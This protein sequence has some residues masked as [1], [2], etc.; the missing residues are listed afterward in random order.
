MDANVFQVRL[1]FVD[2]NVFQVRLYFVD[3]SVFQFRLY[4]WAP[5]FSKSAYIL[6]TPMFSISYFSSSPDKHKENQET[7]AAIS[8]CWNAG[9]PGKKLV[10]HFYWLS[11]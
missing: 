1:Y 9:I 2:A 6:L 3:A 10:R 8:K 7:S 4:F 5:M 11:T